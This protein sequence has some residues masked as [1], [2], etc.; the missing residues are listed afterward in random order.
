MGVELFP[1]IIKSIE[2]PEFSKKPIAVIFIN[3]PQQAEISAN[4]LRKF[5]PNPIQVVSINQ[6]LQTENFSAAFLTHPQL[7]NDRL[8][9]HTAHLNILTFSPFYQAIDYKI[10]TGLVVK[11][12][13]RPQIN[14]QQIRAKRI[15]FK[16][17]FLRVA[18][19]HE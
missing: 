5:L 2:T 9:Q 7:H 3:N 10:D 17:F 12:Q 13:V 16:P 19:I 14:L 18:E 6:F 4:Q 8:I 15:V 1:V 11:E